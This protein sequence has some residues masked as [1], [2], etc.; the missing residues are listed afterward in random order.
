MSLKDEMRKNLWTNDSVGG[1]SPLWVSATT[2]QEFLG[3]V[4]TQFAHLW[5]SMQASETCLYINTSE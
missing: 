1:L 3:C 2:G 5:A 4:R